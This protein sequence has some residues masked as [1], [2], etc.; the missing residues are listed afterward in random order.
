MMRWAPQR[1]SKTVRFGKNWDEALPTALFALRS[2]W[3]RSRK[4][5]PIHIMFGHPA[6]TVGEW[7][8]FGDDGQSDTSSMDEE[9]SDDDAFETHQAQ[10]SNVL[11]HCTSYNQT[12]RE[13]M[14]KK[15]NKRRGIAYTPQVGHSTW[16]EKC[17]FIAKI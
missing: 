14:I 10:L 1:T 7:E 6:F 2:T 3:L 15:A 11:D 8:L 13:N 16:S 5:S 17:D 9:D 12:A 4:F